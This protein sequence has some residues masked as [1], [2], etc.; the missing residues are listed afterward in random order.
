MGMGMGVGF[1]LFIYF[2]GGVGVLD[3]LQQSKARNRLFASFGFFFPL[4]WQCVCI[5]ELNIR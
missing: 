1:Y 5:R 4:Y 2:G 3:P